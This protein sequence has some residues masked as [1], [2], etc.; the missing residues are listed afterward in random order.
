MRAEPSE[1]AMNLVPQRGLEP[2]LPDGNYT[3]NVARLPIPPLR[4]PKN[5]PRDGTTIPSKMPLLPRGIF[6]LPSASGSVKTLDSA[7][8]RLV[9]DST[10]RRPERAG[11]SEPSTIVNTLNIEAIDAVDGT[12]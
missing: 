2:P 9:S 4:R 11:T 10:T 1:R 6:I 7:S 12:G 8:S 5:P 3:L